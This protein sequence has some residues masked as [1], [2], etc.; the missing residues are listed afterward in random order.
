MRST[1]SQCSSYYY[2]CS[3]WSVTVAI[4]KFT[5]NE[6]NISN[7]L[8][9][10]IVE[11][12]YYCSFKK[13]QKTLSEF[14]ADKVM[15]KNNVNDNQIGIIYSDTHQRFNI[16]YENQSITM[17]SQAWSPSTINSSQIRVGNDQS[18]GRQEYRFSLASSGSSVMKLMPRRSSQSGQCE[19]HVQH[20]RPK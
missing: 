19:R 11:Q 4:T 15:I 6:N 20:L 5:E 10:K 16:M 1:W 12:Q 3:T 8:A 18:E 2:L 17:K 14:W 7:H 9:M 13:K